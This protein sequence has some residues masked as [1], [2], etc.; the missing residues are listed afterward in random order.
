MENHNQINKENDKKKKE[1]VRREQKQF[2]NN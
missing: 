2:L 1:I